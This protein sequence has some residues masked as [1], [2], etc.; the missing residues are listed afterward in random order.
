MGQVYI[1]PVLQANSAGIQRQAIANRKA[2]VRIAETSYQ[3][4]IQRNKNAEMS[5]KLLDELTQVG[6][7]AER[8]VWLKWSRTIP[9]IVP[10]KR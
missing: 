1:V 2:A 6:D 4:C 10:C 8:A 5:R 7:K 9:P 3:E